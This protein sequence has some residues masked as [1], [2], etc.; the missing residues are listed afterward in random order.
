[1]TPTIALLT[2]F[3]HRDA[4]VGIMKSVIRRICV[5]AELIDLCH[6][7]PPQN[8]LSGA[9]Q[10]ATARPFLPNDCIVLAVVD[11]GVGTRR[12]P[13]AIESEGIRFVGPDNGLFTMAVERYDVGSAVQLTNSDYHL[14]EVSHTF[15][16]R[17]IFA[18]AAA[19]LA[20]GVALADLGQALD[21]SQLVRLP[22]IGPLIKSD[23][24]ECTV[25]HVDHF[26]NAVTN[27]HT[28]TLAATGREVRE[29]STSDQKAPF[30]E[31]FFSVPKQK[32]VAYMGSAGYLEIGVRN[33]NAAAELQIGQGTL[34][35]VSLS[36]TT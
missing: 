22:G 8:V 29:V 21:T 18:P 6:E 12:R 25:V 10:L 35:H 4:Y 26:G 17:D 15:H 13:I 27:L 31:G 1:M 28:S 2:D 34:V 33:G 32:P 7:I 23:S 9:Y 3:G 19:H 24:I 11:P 14:P 36:A 5:D 30:G 20:A 16:G